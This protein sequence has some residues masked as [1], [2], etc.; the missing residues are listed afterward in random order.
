MTE[1]IWYSASSF[2]TGSEGL[3]TATNG[4][5]SVSIIFY[6][7]TTCGEQSETSENITVTLTSTYSAN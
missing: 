7:K 4:G 3:T 5:D 6:A 1:N 2:V